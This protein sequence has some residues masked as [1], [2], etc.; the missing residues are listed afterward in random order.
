MRLLTAHQ[1][2][3]E[4]G[5]S[6]KTYLCVCEGSF[7]IGVIKALRLW[8]HCPHATETF[9]KELSYLSQLRK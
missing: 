8:Q 4:T 6:D 9:Y 2:E 5:F 7:I 1:Q 3:S